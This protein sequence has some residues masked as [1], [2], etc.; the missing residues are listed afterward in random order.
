MDL[1]DVDRFDGVDECVGSL[2]SHK[3]E[4][5]EEGEWEGSASL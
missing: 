3:E 4:G 5:K 1:I 2:G